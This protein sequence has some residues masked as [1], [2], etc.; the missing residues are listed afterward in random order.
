MAADV[1]LAKRSSWSSTLEIGVRLMDE[2]AI[3]DFWAIVDIAGGG[4][5]DAEADTLEQLQDELVRKVGLG[6]VDAAL[7]KAEDL[8]ELVGRTAAEAEVAL[9]VRLSMKPGAKPRLAWAANANFPEHGDDGAGARAG[10]FE[11]K[12]TDQRDRGAG[13]CWHIWLNDVVVNASDGGDI[14]SKGG[15]ETADDAKVEA[16]AWVEYLLR[17]G[18]KA[19]E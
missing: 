16:E 15:F 1:I 9:A 18:L 10:W 5:F 7:M 4:T 3:D 19:F 6:D 11:L 17:H 14:R 2:N 8:R 12:V 13:W